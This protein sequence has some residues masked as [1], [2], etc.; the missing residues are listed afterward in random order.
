MRSGNAKPVA[1]HEP[2]LD[3][4]GRLAHFGVDTDLVYV[5]THLAVQ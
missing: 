2:L 5:T 3:Y 4:G 1:I